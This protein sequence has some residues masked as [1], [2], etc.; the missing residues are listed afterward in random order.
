MIDKIQILS[1]EIGGSCDFSVEHPWCPSNNPTRYRDAKTLPATDDHFL[2]FLDSALARNF[3]GLVAFHYYNEPAQQAER[4]E[5]LIEEIDK[6]K[7]KTL[8]WTNGYK[9][10]PELLPSFDYV[11]R[12]GYE[13]NGKGKLVPFQPDDRL[14]IY[15]TAPSAVE[16]ACYRPM[17]L[18]MIVNYHGDMR[19]CCADW[20]G[21]A[22]IG[23]IQI[24]PHDDLFARWETLTS[25]VARGDL[26][27]CKRCHALEKSP[28]LLNPNWKVL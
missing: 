26:D 6:R 2:N 22:H 23:N 15:D 27:V 18:E 21:S 28:A 13:K 17:I 7:I 1:F 8:L 19:L 16:C 14:Q 4:C 9:V 11:F 20:A 12:T 10:S 24:D 5:K 3:S 25:A